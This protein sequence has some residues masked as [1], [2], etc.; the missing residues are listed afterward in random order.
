MSDEGHDRTEPAT[1]RRREEARKKGQVPH[2][3]DLAASAVLLAGVVGLWLLGPDVGTGF[4][5]L[6]RSQFSRPMPDELGP[7]GVKELLAQQLVQFLRLGVPLMVLPVLAAL[8]A[9]FVQAGFH[10]SPERVDPDFERLSPASGMAR[11]FSWAAVFKG[12]FG[13]VKVALLGAVVVAVVRPRAGVFASLGQADVSTAVSLAWPLVI[14][15]GLFLGVA[16]LLLGV[17]D[18]AYQRF[19]FERS[20]RMTKQEVK[21]EAKREEGDPL[22]RNRM[23]QLQRDRARQRMLDEV[24]RATALVTNPTHVAVALRYDRA[25]MKA[26]R[27]IAR[28]AGDLAQRMIE[29][30]RRHGIPVLVRPPV[31]RALFRGVALGAE[32]PQELFV[33]VAEI[34]AFVYRLRAGG[35]PHHPGGT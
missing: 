20:L 15:L 4:L 8:V 16:F 28:G 31:A 14:R 1:P 30:A 25:T 11:L 22:V 35:P 29:C 34:I 5:G 12:I 7:A 17:A 33:A 2:S 32:V 19:R 27:V 23:R 21:E 6:L 24:P 13:L 3:G 26:P 9:G 18:F 10:I